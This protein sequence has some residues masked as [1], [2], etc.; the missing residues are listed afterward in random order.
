[1]DLGL[2]Y[3]LLTEFTSF[4]AVDNSRPADKGKSLQKSMHNTSGS[5]PE[6]HEWSLIALGVLLLVFLLFAN[7]GAFHA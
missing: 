4:V 3:N 7:K 6:P 1:V 2:K 5:V